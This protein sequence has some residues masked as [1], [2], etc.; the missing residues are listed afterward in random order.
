MRLTGSMPRSLLNA[1]PAVTIGTASVA[2]IWMI[3]PSRSAPMTVRQP[4]S[5]SHLG[6][7]GI[8]SPARQP[9][10]R[11]QRLCASFMHRRGPRGILHGEDQVDPAATDRQPVARP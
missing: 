4:T 3:P 5:L 6:S 2:V 9:L 7:F 11:G 1:G 8:V 10:D